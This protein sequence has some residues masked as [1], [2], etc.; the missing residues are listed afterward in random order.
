[1]SQS[2][3]SGLLTIGSACPLGLRSVGWMD[4]VFCL[5]ERL[6]QVRVVGLVGRDV[7]VYIYMMGKDLGLDDFWV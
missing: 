4:D 3:P 2:Y 1:M 6:Y 5:G 7:Y